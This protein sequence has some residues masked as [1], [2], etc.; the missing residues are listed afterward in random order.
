MNAITTTTAGPPIGASAMIPRS[1]RDAMELA[2]MMAK[3]G[4][5]PQQIQTPGGAL[6]VIEQ[7]MRWNMSPFA[8]ATEVSFIS[9]KPMFSGKIV[10]AAVQTSG[11]MDGRLSTNTPAAARPAASPCA[12][13]F[14]A[15]PS[16]APSR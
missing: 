11:A 5:L 16:P 4:F 1:M 3:T 12:A 2:T 14:A 15:R 9:G 10:A 13:P 7:A 8:V 6:F